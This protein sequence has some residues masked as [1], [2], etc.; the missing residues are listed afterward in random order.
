[1]RR[2]T[3]LGPFPFSEGFPL[4]V[5][6]QKKLKRKKNWVKIFRNGKTFFGHFFQFPKNKEI[7]A[8]ILNKI[9]KK[10]LSSP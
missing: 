8:G 10:N 1:M 5:I 9:P 2:S 4:K 3:V 6:K 7:I